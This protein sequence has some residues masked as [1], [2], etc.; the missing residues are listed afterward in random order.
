[1]DLVIRKPLVASASFLLF[2]IS[3]VSLVIMMGLER[4][5]GGAHLPSKRPH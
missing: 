5:V 1:V 3:L 4:V 2:G